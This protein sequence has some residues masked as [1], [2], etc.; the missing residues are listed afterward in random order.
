M[1]T[2]DDK[3]VTSSPLRHAILASSPI[4]VLFLHHTSLLPQK[5]ISSVQ[6]CP[7]RCRGLVSG[8]RASVRFQKHS[9]VRALLGFI[10]IGQLM[11]LLHMDNQTLGLLLILQGKGNPASHKDVPEITSFTVDAHHAADCT[12]K[13]KHPRTSGEG[14]LPR[15]HHSHLPS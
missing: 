11:A 12:L 8:L 3:K 10:S 9:R 5:Q 15:P 1:V 14:T 7:D 6:E 2:C 13:I 4:L